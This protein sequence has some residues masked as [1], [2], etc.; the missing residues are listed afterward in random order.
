M[1]QKASKSLTNQT[2]PLI[3]EKLDDI[4]SNQAILLSKVERNLYKDLYKKNKNINELK[5]LY[6]KRFGITARQFNSCR[7]KLEGKVR[8]YRE[9]LKRNICL[10]EDKIKKLKK[11]IQKLKD[12]LKSHQKKRRLYLLESKLKK[13]KKDKEE[14]KIRICFGSKKLFQKQFHLEENGYLSHAEWKEDWEDARNSAFFLVGSKDETAGNQSCQLIK[15]KNSF[16][17]HLRLPNGFSEKTLVLENITF[18]YGTEELTYCLEENEKRKRLRLAKK[19]YSHFGKALNFLFKKDKKGWR[20]FVTIEKEAPDLKSKNSIGTIG[21]D[22]NA[23]HIAFSETDRCGNIINKKTFS[24]TTYGK[25]KKQSLAII[26]DVSKEI[27]KMASLAEKPVVLEDLNFEKKKTDLREK[28]DKYS[29]MLSSFSYNKIIDSIETKAFKE[30]IKIYKV[31][32]AFT[33]IIGKVKFACRYGLSDHHAAAFV[34]ARRACNYSER[35]PGCLEVIGN[36]K[37]KSAFSLPERNREKHVWNFYS[38]LSK[39]LKAANVLHKSTKYR[40]SRP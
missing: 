39:E 9:L 11:H 29:R 19:E 14:N 26:G 34:I 37:S 4:L 30:G 16:T 8:S 1:Q 15:T 23:D 7:I 22:I 2:R 27:I 12:P 13:R 10:L 6:L 17:L 20:V 36:K 25:S 18:G 38:E 24:C 35:P 3:E 32:P 31:N 21:I 28:S 33:S 5:S 40:S